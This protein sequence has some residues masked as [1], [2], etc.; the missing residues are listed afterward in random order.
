[1]EKKR[2]PGNTDQGHGLFGGTGPVLL[3]AVC[4]I[5]VLLTGG[6]LIAPIVVC[7]AIVLAQRWREVRNG[8]EEEA[9]KY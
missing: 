4:L 2:K 7:V 3:A 6:L 8:E 9:R 1:M 5:V